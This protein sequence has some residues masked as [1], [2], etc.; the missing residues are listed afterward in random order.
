MSGSHEPRNTGLVLQRG[1]CIEGH[2][3]V[4]KLTFVKGPAS[5]GYRSTITGQRANG[6]SEPDTA[7]GAMYSASSALRSQ[8]SRTSGSA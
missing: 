5:V 4:V 1:I 7:A 3:N 2:K 8:T 6:T